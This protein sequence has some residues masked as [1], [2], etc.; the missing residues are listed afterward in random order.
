MKIGILTHYDVNNQ[1][2][3]LQLYALKA[4]LEEH[5]HTVCI[6]SYEKNYDFNKN[7]EKRNSGS[8]LNVTYYVNEYLIKKGLGLTLFNTLKMLNH[9]KLRSTVEMLPYDDNDCDAIIIGSDEVYSIDVGCNKMMYGN[10]LKGKLAIAYAP[11]FGR[12][13]IDLLKELKC[14]ETVK[15]GLNSMYAL[16]ARDLHTQEMILE[17]T[18]KQAPLVCDPVLLYS[19]KDFSVETKPIKK[20]YMIVY[21]YD[22][23]MNDLSEIKAIKEY[24][25]KHNLTIVS[26]GTYHKW[27][28]KNVVCNA[29]QWYSYFKDAECVVTD[30][31]HGTVVAMK[32]HCNVAVCIRKSINSFKMQSLLETTGTE[33]RLLSEISYDN[34]ER[35][36]S[37][38]IDYVSVDERIGKMTESSEKYLLEALGGI[39]E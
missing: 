23:N 1:G 4:W 28:D 14:Y 31:F 8:F 35:I 26:L 10:G 30:T 29:L 17:L 6:L 19:G 22:A 3:Q 7:E 33:D 38:S 2:A 34:L 9:R 13:T 5:G 36:L 11:S 25:K 21:S 12:S 16:S 18:G 20:K 15:E 32:N 24:T 39:N 37:K 27:C